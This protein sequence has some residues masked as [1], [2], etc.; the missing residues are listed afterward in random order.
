MSSSAPVALRGETSFYFLSWSEGKLLILNVT[1]SLFRSLKGKTRH[2]FNP[3]YVSLREIS[4]FGLDLECTGKLAQFVQSKQTEEE[5]EHALRN[6]QTKKPS[7][8]LC[9]G[10]CGVCR[11]AHVSTCASLYRCDQQACCTYGSVLVMFKVI[12]AGASFIKHDLQYD[13]MRKPRLSSSLL[14]L[15]LMWK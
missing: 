9:R 12:L 11:C 6:V 10:A 7:S 1:L 14:N 15:P 8:L 4:F 3:S 5:T 2:T 13:L